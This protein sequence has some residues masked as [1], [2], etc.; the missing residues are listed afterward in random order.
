[1]SKKRQ[2]YTR[3]VRCALLM[4]SLG[5]V[6]LAHNPTSSVE[7]LTV[8]QAVQYALEHNP[9]LRKAELDVEKAGDDL[10]AYRT[11]RLPSIKWDV[12]AGQLLTKPSLT[13]N[14]GVFG[15]Y[16]GIGPIPSEQTKVTTPRRPAAVAFGQ[17]VQPL[18]QQYRLGLQVKSYRLEQQLE[19]AKLAERRA[20]V[21]EEVRKAYYKLLQTQS[22]L[23]SVEE[24]LPL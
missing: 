16:Q 15:T 24:S 13:F 12:L 19:A 10:A 8:D 5:M 9:S 6:A 1:M 11:R 2:R 21:A 23:E 20:A 14:R 18:S 3:T 22:S 7:T 17:I 4:G